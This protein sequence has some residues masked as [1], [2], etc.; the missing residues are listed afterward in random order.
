MFI[1]KE[2]ITPSAQYLLN[3]NP[4]AKQAYT[5]V[6]ESIKSIVTDQ[7][8][9]FY[10]NNTEKNGNGVVPI[11]EKCYIKLENDFLWF[12]EKPLAYLKKEMK[13]GGPIDVYKEFFKDDQQ[14][15]V[16]L[17]FETGNISSAHRSMNKLAVGLKRKEIQLAILMMPIKQLSFYLTDR[18]SNYEE[19]EPYFCI[20]E[21]NPY[22]IIGFDAEHYCDNVPFLP[23][24]K[25]GMSHRS[26]RKW[27]K[28]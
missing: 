25:D 19:L 8:S 10:I 3:N 11:K 13:K 23:K 18:V 22:I 4:L 28:S 26:T 7:H 17:E 5:E 24:G 15:N 16:G 6:F 2:Y 9:E 12:R 21:D 20:V 27:N 14:L 1:A